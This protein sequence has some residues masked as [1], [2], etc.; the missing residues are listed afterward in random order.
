VG[1]VVLDVIGPRLGVL[2][3]EVG[4]VDA[5]I[6]SAKRPSITKTGPIFPVS[7]AG[8]DQ[9]ALGPRALTPH[10]V[11]PGP[12]MTSMRSMSSSITS[13]TSQ[14]TPENNGEYTD[15]PSISTRSL[16][17]DELL[18]PRAL[19]VYSLALARAT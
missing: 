3:I 6:G 8:G 4:G 2:E 17:A 12:L 19:T 5:E 15:R 11:P 16:L 7:A 1:G 18:N 14:N 10:N 9:A 13:C